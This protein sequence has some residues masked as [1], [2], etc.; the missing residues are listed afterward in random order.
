MKYDYFF[1]PSL[2]RLCFS[3]LSIY[4]K[5]IYIY[6]QY[7]K[8][9]LEFKNDGLVHVYQATYISMSSISQKNHSISML[10]D[11]Y[12]QCGPCLFIHRR[13]RKV[14]PAVTCKGCDNLP[15]HYHP[16]LSAHLPY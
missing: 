13:L 10:A 3:Y 1:S 16:I 2:S 6:T 12:F 7:I 15:L 8:V 11:L 4:F 9:I 14:F 5:K